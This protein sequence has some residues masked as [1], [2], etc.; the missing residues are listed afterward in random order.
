[1]ED[2]APRE[3]SRPDVCRVKEIEPSNSRD[4][5]GER[6]NVPQ[7]ELA[8]S[9]FDRKGNFQGSKAGMDAPLAF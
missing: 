3:I 4:G 6:T 2:L 1:M 5:N 8:A 7:Q 9:P